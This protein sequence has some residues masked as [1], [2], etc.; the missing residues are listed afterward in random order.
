[1]R[2]GGEQLNVNCQS[3]TK[4]NSI[5]PYVA[6]SLLGNGEAQDA[7][8]PAHRIIKVAVGQFRKKKQIEPEARV[9]VGDGMARKVW[10]MKQRDLAMQNGV[11]RPRRL[12]IAIKFGT[13]TA[14]W[15][16]RAGR[17]ESEDS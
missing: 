7:D 16:R 3:I 6:A 10:Y 1:M 5:R 8:V 2:E 11:H 4:V 12:A 9:V 15:M 13:T 14:V 17:E